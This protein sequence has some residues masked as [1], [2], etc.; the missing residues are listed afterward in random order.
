MD[1]EYM[2]DVFKSL[3]MP[4]APYIVLKEESKINIPFPLIVKPANSG[5]S[6]GMTKVN[7]K[8]E[9]NEAIEIAK[10]YDNKIIIEKFM[11]IRELEC[12]V[13]ED[14][15]N[16]II[17]DI[18]EIKPAKEFY[19]Y[20]A[21]YENKHSQTIIPADIPEEIK[22]EIKE[23]SKLLF[24][25]FDLKGLSRIDFFYDETNKKV[26]INEINTLPGFT[27]ISMYPKLLM[28]IGISYKDIITKL[29]E[30][31]T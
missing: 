13:L 26:F 3:N 4:Q 24:I 31:A 16:L 20:E 29:I 1:K 18:G 25:K 17:S 21:K 5:S 8:E 12:S 19:D 23:I 14:K 2:K 11:Q 7:N 10:K 6:I 15:D 9:L 30:N 27:K 28:S 22:K